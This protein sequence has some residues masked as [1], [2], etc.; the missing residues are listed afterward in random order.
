MI[1][2]LYDCIRATATDDTPILAK[3]TN[4]SGECI[5]DTCM[6]TLFDDEQTVIVSVPGGLMDDVWHFV[7]PKESTMNLRG[8]YF[9][10]I[11]NYEN[12]ERYCFGKPIYFT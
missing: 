7:I 3:I 4:N 11:S 5:T 12:G 1:E 8:R 9:Y 10:C 6:L 2:Y